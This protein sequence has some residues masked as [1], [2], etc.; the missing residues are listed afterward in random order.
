MKEAGRQAPL[1]DEAE[2][3]WIRRRG[4]RLIVAIKAVPGA[5]RSGLAGLRDGCLLVRVAAPPEKGKAN[6]ELIACLAKSLGISKTAIELV[7]G[8][9]SRRKQVA[10]PVESEA[11]LRS[12]AASTGAKPGE[13]PPRA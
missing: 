13:T 5:A 3:S 11:L 10:L 9:S 8:G 4:E 1:R 2:A 7:A 6:D 12:L